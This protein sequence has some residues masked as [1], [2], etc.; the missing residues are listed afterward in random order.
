MTAVI[1]HR[2]ATASE[3]RSTLLS[4]ASCLVGMGVF[5]WFLSPP[6]LFVV[7]FIAIVGTVASMLIYYA[8]VNIQTNSTFVC[9]IDN[10]RIR[11]VSPVCQ[12]GD[13]FSIPL[14][15]I[16]RLEKV[17]EGESSY[18]WYIWD[19][20]GQRFWLTSNYDNPVDTFIEAF[21]SGVLTLLS[22]NADIS[23]ETCRRAR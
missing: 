10:Q 16:A 9:R 13:S 20:A 11:C 6:G 7:A 3:G 1:E 14:R 15:T 12:C 8:V 18:K 4:I 22:F 2:K 21:E 19:E 5:L 17:D 23:R